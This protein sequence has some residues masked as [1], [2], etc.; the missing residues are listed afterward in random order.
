MKNENV[1]NIVISM[2][3]NALAKK[4]HKDQ[5]AA[6]KAAE[7]ERK[8][9]MNKHGVEFRYLWELRTRLKKSQLTPQ[10]NSCTST[11]ANEPEEKKA[12]VLVVPKRKELTGMNV[13][14]D[15]N[16][17]SSNPDDRVAEDA[18]AAAIEAAKAAKL[19]QEEFEKHQKERAEAAKAAEYAAQ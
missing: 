16:S 18:K 1:W 15:C 10:A 8:D 11:A 17:Q 14:T 2:L 7:I 12:E 19:A 5:D 13:E 6:A 3:A 4:K 9:L